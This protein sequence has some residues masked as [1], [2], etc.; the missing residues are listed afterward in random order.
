MFFYRKKPKI[1][2]AQR[3]DSHRVKKA[4]VAKTLLSIEPI[5]FYMLVAAVFEISANVLVPE[6]YRIIIHSMSFGLGIIL[7]GYISFNS[8]RKKRKISESLY[9]EH[10][11]YLFCKYKDYKQALLEIR[12]MF[13]KKEES[14]IINMALFNLSESGKIQSAMKYIEQYFQGRKVKLLHCYILESER[15]PNYHPPAEILTCI[16]TTP[17]LDY[18]TGV[19]KRKDRWTIFLCALISMSI[20][21]V[22]EAVGK[23]GGFLPGSYESSLSRLFAFVVFFV[24]FFVYELKEMVT[25]GGFEKMRV[26]KGAMYL[27]DLTFF[28]LVMPV[29]KAIEKS[30]EFADRSMKRNISRLALSLKS[31]S[32]EG[33]LEFSD[34]FD[35][36][37]IKRIMEFLYAK[38]AEPYLAPAELTAML[39]QLDEIMAKELSKRMFETK[40][41]RTN[42]LLAPQLATFVMLF[43]N[44]L[45]LVESVGRKL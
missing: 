5:L 3:T 33:Y 45:S 42:I 37:I 9:V 6:K 19:G 7:P 14:R 27:K 31:N 41:E 35:N 1:Y 16:T 36:E 30:V 44:I 17:S 22:I 40:R 11:T 23:E 15:R 20:C 39:R 32:A 26:M 25:K 18:R 34:R 13:P 10:M 2:S 4:K 8:W 28:L 21:V 29:S 43:G 38:S 12:E 24:V